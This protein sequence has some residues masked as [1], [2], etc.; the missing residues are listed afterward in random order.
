MGSNFLMSSNLQN[1]LHRRLNFLTGKHYSRLLRNL[2]YQ[3]LGDQTSSAGALE[4]ATD[5]ICIANEVQHWRS[6]PSGRRMSSGLTLYFLWVLEWPT[7]AILAVNCRPQSSQI[8]RLVS[9]DLAAGTDWLGL[10]S[11]THLLYGTNVYTHIYN[12]WYCGH[13]S[14]L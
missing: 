6:L 13:W 14:V 3:N 7:R 12:R 11:I 2:V 10:H 4:T 1:F 9:A 8:K 5:R